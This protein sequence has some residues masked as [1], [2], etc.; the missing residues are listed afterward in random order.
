[1][2]FYQGENHG[3]PNS[4][5]VE[6]PP[7]TA[8]GANS[9]PGQGVKIPHAL[10]PKSQNM[11]EKQYCNKFNKDFFNGPNQK[12][13]KKG[14]KYRGESRVESKLW[15][16]S[17][18]SPLIKR[19]TEIIRKQWKAHRCFSPSCLHLCTSNWA[20]HRDLKGLQDWNWT[21]DM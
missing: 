11:K 20:H 2:P 14:E 7:C 1:M 4:P 21:V 9:I 8:A 3:L 15:K 10:W 19:S 17:P 13:K 16:A 6:A 12:K 5:V 18:S